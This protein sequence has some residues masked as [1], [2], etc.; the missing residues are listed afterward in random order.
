MFGSVF[1]L[2]NKVGLGRRPQKNP[3]S[4]TFYPEFS[5]RS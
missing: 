2:K 3:F 4:L 1:G 5:F